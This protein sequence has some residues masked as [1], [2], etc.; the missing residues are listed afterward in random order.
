ML[1]ASLS[2]LKRTPQFNATGS[3]SNIE[4]DAYRTGPK[5]IIKQV[6]RN[7]QPDS[8]TRPYT[9]AFVNV[10]VASAHAACF[11]SSGRIR[12]GFNQT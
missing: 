1:S 12:S 5:H 6:G 9:A 7:T 2:G 10:V 3:T 8:R 11:K 4:T